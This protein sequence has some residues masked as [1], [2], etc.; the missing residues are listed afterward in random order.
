MKKA[1]NKK[2]IYIY[3][4]PPTVDYLNTKDQRNPEPKP[5]AIVTAIFTSCLHLS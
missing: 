1:I 3:P 2:G 4:S 5:E